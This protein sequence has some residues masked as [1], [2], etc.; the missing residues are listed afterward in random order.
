MKSAQ[1]AGRSFCGG[2]KNIYI[3]KSHKSDCA[4]ILNN[5]VPFTFTMKLNNN[6]ILETFNF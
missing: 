3:F 2:L 6:V 4:V 5:M 1:A